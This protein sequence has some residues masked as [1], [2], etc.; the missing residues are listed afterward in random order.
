MAGPTYCSRLWCVMEI[1][2]FLFMGGKL[3]RIEIHALSSSD[4][5]HAEER[6]GVDS[7]KEQFA[8]FDAAVNATRYG[9]VEHSEC[10][11]PRK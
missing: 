1:F 9:R 4:Q 6:R 8:S 2:T 10:F 3:E 5:G 7:L 11:A